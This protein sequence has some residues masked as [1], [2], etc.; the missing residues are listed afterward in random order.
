MKQIM[1]SVGVPDLIYLKWSE[2]LKTL[3]EQSQ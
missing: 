2:K 3:A 1:Y